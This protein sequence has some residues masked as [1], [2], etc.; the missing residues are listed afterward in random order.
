MRNVEEIVLSCVRWQE[1]PGT[2][3][4][5]KDELPIQVRGRMNDIMVSYLARFG[6]K[7]V[8][9]RMNN[10]SIAQILSEFDSG[11]P[12]LVES[13]EVEGVVYQLYDRPVPPTGE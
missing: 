7:G 3:N 9:E 6:P 5:L 8:F 2:Y 1:L 13:G 4:R 10:R 12:K 11:Q